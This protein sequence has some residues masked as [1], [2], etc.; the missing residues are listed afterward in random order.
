MIPILRDD[1]NKDKRLIYCTQLFCTCQALITYSGDEAFYPTANSLDTL[2]RRDK[3]E[4]VR[5][6]QETMTR[7]YEFF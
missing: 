6:L 1:R 5:R 4:D 7:Q 3:P 2:A